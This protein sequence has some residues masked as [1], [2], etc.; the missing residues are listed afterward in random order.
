MPSL[1]SSQ[2]R[3]PTS[4]AGR[5]RNTGHG[6]ARQVKLLK[7]AVV[8]EEAKPDIRDPKSWKRVHLNTESLSCQFVFITHIVHFQ[9]NCGT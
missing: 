3:E 7:P 6:A 8:V 1:P 9:G 2:T 5:P 4:I